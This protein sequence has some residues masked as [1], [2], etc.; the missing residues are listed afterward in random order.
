MSEESISISNLN[1]FVFCPVSI[2]FHEIDH[3]TGKLLY[4]DSYQLNGT[5]AHEKT[6]HGQYS[7]RISILQGTTVYSEKYNLIGKIDVFD[8]DRGLLAE[9][10]KHISTIY[11]G[12]VFQLY[13]Q[14]F[15]LIE[16]GYSVKKLRLYSYDDNKSYFVKL[17]A[18]DP[19]MFCKFEEL[20]NRIE[21]F[22]FDSFV[23][24]NAAKC[25]HCIYESLCSFS[26]LKE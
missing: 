26:K 5:A 13:A 3:D 15:S 1:D 16:M 25:S 24:D 22:S 18:D 19:I 17:P 23:Q 4:Q 6:D 7:D 11:D 21:Q 10:K 12:Y 14:Y 8:I 2:Y 9:R 20:L